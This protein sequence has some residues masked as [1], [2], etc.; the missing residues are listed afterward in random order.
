MIFSKN[1]VYH[2]YIVNRIQIII[3][4]KIL[5]AGQKKSI[6]NFTWSYLK[7]EE[8]FDKTLDRKNDIKIILYDRNWKIYCN[9]N[10]QKLCEGCS[11]ER[12]S[13]NPGKKSKINNKNVVA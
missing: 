10:T 4:K 13:P 7:S 1:Y 9:Y 2:T 3:N 11:V 8:H 12:V 5:L 6:I